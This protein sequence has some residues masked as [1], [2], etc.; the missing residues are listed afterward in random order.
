MQTEDSGI[1]AAVDVEELFE[2]RIEIRSDKNCVVSSY[3]TQFLSLW[4]AKRW[5]ADCGLL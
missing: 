4:T 3:K 1:Y 5:L 2:Y